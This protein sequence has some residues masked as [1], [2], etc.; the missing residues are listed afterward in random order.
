MNDEGIR[1]PNVAPLS[2][3]HAQG[4]LL[5]PHSL[6]EKVKQGQ[7]S[8]KYAQTVNHPSPNDVLR[9][10]IEPSGAQ[11]FRVLASGSNAA[12]T[13][14]NMN[15]SFFEPPKKKLWVRMFVLISINQSHAS[16][17]DFQGRRCDPNS[18]GYKN[19]SQA[20]GY[21]MRLL[22]SIFPKMA[23]A[24]KCQFIFNNLE[25]RTSLNTVIFCPYE[26]PGCF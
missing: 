7:A 12:K 5:I 23:L 6:R 18:V 14:R 19:Y 22:S 20:W 2:C 26:M 1:G 8:A 9:W 17:I 24:T 15:T 4:R 21:R 10:R 13:W 16:P 3:C 11:G 25:K